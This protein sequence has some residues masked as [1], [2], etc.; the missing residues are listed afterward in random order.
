MGESAVVI[1]RRLANSGPGQLLPA[2][3]DYFVA[4]REKSKL[5]SRNLIAKINFTGCAE[6]GNSKFCIL[7]FA[8]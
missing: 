3:F 5:R 1:E 4:L 6:G 2:P 7:C 8:A